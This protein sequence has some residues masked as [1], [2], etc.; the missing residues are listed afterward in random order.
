[1][2]RQQKYERFVRT[3]FGF[4]TTGEMLDRWGDPAGVATTDC[5]TDSNIATVKVAT[6][7]T[8]EIMVNAVLK[9]VSV[10]EAETTRLEEFTKK[11]VEASDLSTIDGL[12]TDFW[13]TVIDKFFNISSGSITLKKLSRRQPA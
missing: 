3:A 1:M 11:V 5:F 12:I 8:M 6:G 4:G 2:T 10:S 7:Y 13:D 9:H